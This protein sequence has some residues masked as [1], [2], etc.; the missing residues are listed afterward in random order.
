M[1]NI[2]RFSKAGIL[3]L[4]AFRLEEIESFDKGNQRI[5]DV[6]HGFEF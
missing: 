5:L 4:K 2:L 1:L 6:R 3:K